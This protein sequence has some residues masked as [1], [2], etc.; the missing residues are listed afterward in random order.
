MG[1]E[2]R[3]S[4]IIFEYGDND[5]E[6]WDGD[7]LTEEEKNTIHAILLKHTNE[8]FS[9]RGTRK[10]IADKIRKQFRA[11]KMREAE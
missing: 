11:R 4:G 10:E 7:Y 6:L 1:E 3:I 8:G 2:M 9:I 5:V